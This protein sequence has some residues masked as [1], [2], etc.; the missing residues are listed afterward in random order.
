METLQLEE[1]VLL[2]TDDGVAGI[3]R[4]E[5]VVVDGGGGGADTVH[6]PDA[7]HQPRGIPRA[8]VIDD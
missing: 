1:G 7:L 4:V 2:Q 3:G 5:H 6:T 8:V